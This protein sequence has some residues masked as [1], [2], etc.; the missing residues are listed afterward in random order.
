MVPTLWADREL[1]AWHE[2]RERRL[3][4][5]DV[6]GGA[7]MTTSAKQRSIPSAGEP[8]R[9]VRS[10]C[11]FLAVLATAAAPHLEARTD[12]QERTDE[13]R[14][15]SQVR[16]LTYEGRR[17]GE[18][19]FGARGQAMV[20]Q[21]EREPGN[22]FF[23]IYHLD[24]T[25]GDSRRVS[26]GIGKA[27]CGFLRPDGAAAL[28][29]SSHLDPDAAAKQQ[30]EIDFRASGR[31]RRYS[32]DYDPH[33]DIFTAAPDGSKLTRL[34]TSAG[35]DAEG[36]YSPDGKKIVFTSLRGA[37]PASDLGDEDRKRLEVDPA[38]FGDIY[39][40][41]AD[42]TDQRRLT[43]TPGYDGGPFFFADGSRVV[44]RRFDRKGAIA[45][46]HTMRVDGTDE[47]RLTDFKSISWAPF[48]HPSGEYVVFASNKYGFANFELFLVDVEGERVPTRVTFTDGF[49]GLPTFSPDGRQLSWTSNRTADGTSQIFLA[50]WNHDAARAALA[51]APARA[52]TAENA[53]DNGLRAA[54]EF[55]AS[56]EL[57]GRFTGSP[58]AQRAADYIARRLQALGLAPLGAGDGFFHPF[59]FTAGMETIPDKTSL[60][61]GLAFQAETNFRPLAFSD[62]GEV[63]GEVVFAGYGLS[64]PGPL[65]EGYDSFADLD[66]TD[67]IALVLRYVP[68]GVAAERR[69]ELNRYA[70]LRYKALLAR[71]RGAKAILVV[72][73]PNSPNAGALAPMRFD[74]SVA[75]SGIVAMSVDLTVA[76]H[77]F[78]ASGKSLRTV[79]AA[80][81]QENPHFQGAF[82]LG[83]N[84]AVSVGIKRVEK[85][86]RNVVALLPPTPPASG[87]TAPPAEYVLVGAHYDHIGR[88]AVGS[89]ADKDERGEVHNGAD[90]NASGTAVVLRLAQLLSQAETR[91]RGVVFA[92][93]SGEELGLVG[94]SRFVADPPVPLAEIV[95]YL[96]FDMV[97]RLRDNKLIVQAVGSSNLWRRLIER[98]NV[99]A[100]F[101]LVLQDDPY[102]PTDSTAFYPKNVPVLSFFTGSHEHYNRP[103]DDAETLNYRG[104]ARIAS[105]AAALVDDLANRED[106]PEYA[107]VERAAGQGSR[108]GLRVYLG[109]IPD[110]ATE[111]A[112]VK[113]SGVR[114]GSPADQAGLRGGD[115]IVEF[116]GQAI[117]NIYDYTYAL[118]AA[119]IGESVRVVV[120]RAGERVAVSVTPAAADSQ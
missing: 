29:A 35:Y 33:M 108:D 13:A 96:N 78:A 45:D 100:G 90:D 55:L 32:W 30:A 34:T 17:A 74:N 1:G 110:Y 89:L 69:Q 46:V 19:Y 120:L 77:L 98:H 47:R 111:S 25:T 44:W 83:V 2:Y 39:I 82:P 76:D 48:P 20:L 62:D 105:Y 119:R 70:G 21:S 54:V 11:F 71:E 86:D 43:N 6:D 12:A 51:A 88:G 36:A 22:P 37:Y 116:G 27:T 94:S 53:A 5:V 42:G 40:M 87:K 106:R 64:V 99:P 112:G 80:L 58:G 18:G 103:S 107:K 118:D 65:G 7:R 93:W 67:K 15:L 68:E 38:Y 3:P 73:G 28:F 81:D 56:D 41:N 8:R 59:R 24:L 63:A 97:G 50:D 31:T 92:F 66:M 75:G 114:D 109:T 115:M 4:P 57:E 91:R 72:T 101:Q 102:L 113:L 79:Q 14:F 60:A 52:S 16:Q 26:P 10:P 95:A 9:A 104:M 117:A 85:P 23:Q 49:D 61:A 84:A